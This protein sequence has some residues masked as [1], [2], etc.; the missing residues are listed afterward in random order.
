MRLAAFA[1]VVLV[2]ATPVVALAHGGGLDGLGC[3]HNRK[4]GGYHCHRGS[5]AGQS[6]RSKSEAL[7]ALRGAGPQPTPKAV[8]S[9]SPTPI[10]GPA[11]ISISGPVSV[12]DGDTI[13][14]AGQR[15]R[16]HGIDAPETKQTCR[17][18]GKQWRCGVY[19]GFALA[20][21]IGRHWVH[22]R[23]R[24]RDHY[25]RIVAVCNLAG[26]EGP[27]VNAWIV[28]EGW[29][30]AYRRYS[31]RYVAAENTARE[32]RRGIWKGKFVAPW[33]WRRGKRLAATDTPPGTCP[34]KGNI[35]LRGER[36]YHMPGGQFY[37]H[38]KIN[39]RKGERWFCTE[40]EAK[41]AGWRRSRR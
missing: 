31:T 6:F 20:E 37:T 16:L 35:S 3:H 41:A 17:A 15:V 29:A 34:I 19:A 11:P 1:T 18:D 33:D 26:P 21:M 39:P 28:R 23:E 13:D 25:G 36:I 2:T 32:A 27:N 12:I 30:L 40:A 4:L 14:I 38:T 24:D 9:G 7:A 10:P 22:C 8:P 5:L